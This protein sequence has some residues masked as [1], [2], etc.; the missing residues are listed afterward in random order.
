VQVVYLLKPL[1]GRVVG[2]QGKIL[3]LIISKSGANVQV[4]QSPVVATGGQELC[5]MNVIGPTAGVALAGQMIQEVC[6]SRL[7]LEP[8][9][10]CSFSSR[11]CSGLGQW[12]GEALSLTR[13]QLR[14][15]WSGHQK[16]A[17]SSAAQQRALVSN[18]TATSSTSTSSES[19][20]PA[21]L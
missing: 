20:F 9:S 15:R 14:V 3:Q 6:S 7:C 11:G 12:A 10:S 2:E 17:A 13:S 5:R 16:A 21:L 1:L 4:E 8:L 18:E 19:L